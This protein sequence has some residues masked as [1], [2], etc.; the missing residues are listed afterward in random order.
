MQSEERS[1]MH[2]MTIEELQHELQ[3]AQRTLLNMRFDAGMNRMTNPAGLHNTRKRIAHAEDAHPR[4]RAGGGD[5]ASA[6]WKSI[7]RIRTA[8]RK[9]YR[10]RR[11]A[12]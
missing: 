5:M 3:E 10:E 6:P 1:P 11:K 4:E 8:E 7:K 2:G 12:R 9:A